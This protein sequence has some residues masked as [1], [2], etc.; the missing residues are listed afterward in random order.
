[1]STC[2]PCSVGLLPHPRSGTGAQPNGRLRVTV[3]VRW[4]P[5]VTAAY[6]TWVARPVGEPRRSHLAVTAPAHSW[7]RPVLGD[8]R[9]VGKSL[10][11]SRQRVGRLELRPASRHAACS[12][13]HLVAHLRFFAPIVTADARWAPLAAGRVCTRRV[14]AGSAPSRGRCLSALRPGMARPILAWGVED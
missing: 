2:M 11:G 3:I 12:R 8:H 1:M 9:L 6:G 4:I 14:P 5:L 7:V 10:E 13:P